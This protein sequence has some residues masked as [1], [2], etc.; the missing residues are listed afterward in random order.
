MRAEIKLNHQTRP[1]SYV[2]D[3][4]ETQQATSIISDMKQVTVYLNHGKHCTGSS[5]NGRTTTENHTLYPGDMCIVDPAHSNKHK[6]RGRIGRL[7]GTQ[8]KGIPRLC[9]MDKKGGYGYIN[10][11]DLS[12]LPA[13]LPAITSIKS[14]SQKPHPTFAV[15]LPPKV[16]GDKDSLQRAICLLGNRTKSELKPK[17]Q[18]ELKELIG[19]YPNPQRAADWKKGLKQVVKQSD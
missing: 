19:T 8:R 7:D 16:P 15:D 18:T 14:S 11:V 3:Y 1:D 4:V 13:N 5:D 12:P 2:V 10:P 17:H 9:F 6:Y